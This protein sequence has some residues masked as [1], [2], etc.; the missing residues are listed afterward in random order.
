MTFEGLDRQKT[1]SLLE[2]LQALNNQLKKNREMIEEIENMSGSI[3]HEHD[4]EN[5]Y[6]TQGS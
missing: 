3:I 6:L 5:F 4:T 2:M 1:E